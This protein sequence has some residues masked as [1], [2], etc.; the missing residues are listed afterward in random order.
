MRR[1]VGSGR[2]SQMTLINPEHLR[3]RIER[4]CASHQFILPGQEG[5]EAIWET[6]DRGKGKEKPNK[7]VQACMV[8]KQ[9]STVVRRV[10]LDSRKPSAP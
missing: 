1:L 2:R 7:L 5:A 9:E 3:I 8:T 4:P 6:R 10:K